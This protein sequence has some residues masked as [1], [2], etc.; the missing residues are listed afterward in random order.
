[1][2][3]STYNVIGCLGIAWLILVIPNVNAQTNQSTKSAEQAEDVIKV[4]SELVQTDVMVFDRQGRFVNGLKQEDFEL[5]VDGKPQSISFFDQ[6]QA[7]TAGEDAKLAAARGKALPTKAGEI[8]LAPLDRGRPVFFFVDDLHLTTSSMDQTR[9]LLLRYIERDLK[10]ND[11]AAIIT[12][13]GALGFLEQ[14]TDDKVVLRTAAEHLTARPAGRRD[15]DNPPMSDYEALQ[16]SRG[17]KDTLRYFVDILVKQSSGMVPASIESMVRARAAAIMQQVNVAATK[18]LSSLRNIVH[19]G[20]DVPGRKVLS[21]SLTVLSSTKIVRI[22][23]NGCIQSRLSRAVQ[24]RLFTRLIRGL[25][26]Y[27]GDVENNTPIDTS[28]GL[29]RGRQGEVAASQDVLSA[30]GSNTGG[31]ALLR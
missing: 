22:R 28:G 30:L 6:V 21:F 24:V 18:T 4:Y 5:R 23:P 3:R 29:I 1:M 10:Q 17:D 8:G 31:R 12:A 14:L 19:S 26:A 2:R 20:A 25:T 11:Q 7:G 9:K 16:I 13:S 15:T 27:L